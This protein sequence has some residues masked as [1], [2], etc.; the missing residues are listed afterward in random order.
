MKFLTT[1]ECAVWCTG[2]G[3]RLLQ[4]DRGENGFLDVGSNTS[5]SVV[6]DLPRDSGAKVAIARMVAAL[7][8]TPPEVL[9]WLRNW[10]VWPSSGHQP[11]M[12]RLRQA[13]GEVRPLGEA[14]GHLL[15]PGEAADG[16]SVLVISMCF[17][18]DCAVLPSAGGSFF[19]TSH[20]EYFSFSSE[21]PGDLKRF[22]E[23]VMSILNPEEGH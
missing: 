19:F 4:G 13:L 1:S 16:L 5:N 10:D 17:F 14:P 18:W 23:R 12:T 20:D 8:A 3:Y 11:L 15:V 22:Q 6:F 9:L 7:M 2:H 21:K